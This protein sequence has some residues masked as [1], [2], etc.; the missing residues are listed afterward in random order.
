MAS[1]SIHSFLPSAFSMSSLVAYVVPLSTNLKSKSHIIIISNQNMST[2]SH[3]FC[4]GY[5]VISKPRKY[6]SSLFITIC[7]PSVLFEVA[8]SLF[9]TT[10]P[11]LSNFV[12]SFSFS[13][14][15][16]CHEATVPI[17]HFIHSILVLAVT[18]ASL[19]PLTLNLHPE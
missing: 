6:T 8:V 14:Q 3:S 13:T 10:L 7:C 9:R 15:F 5:S 1:I 11:A 12:R 18:T 4:F 16:S 19:P 17:L 2:P